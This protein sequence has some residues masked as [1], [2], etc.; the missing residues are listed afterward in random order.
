M[1]RWR[2]SCSLLVP[3]PI[4]WSQFSMLGGAI[5]SVYPMLE[6]I[7]INDMFTVTYLTSFGKAINLKQL[8]SV[9]KYCYDTPT[10]TLK[11]IRE[12]DDLAVWTVLW[13]RNLNH[14]HSSAF[15]APFDKISLILRL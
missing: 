8:G 14:T 10:K 13:D 6:S 5:I 2:F 11:Y 12:K 1:G 7:G 3:Q 9:N 4:S 15:S